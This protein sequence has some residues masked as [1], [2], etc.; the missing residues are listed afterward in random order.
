M[1]RR[2]ALCPLK[3]TLPL[4]GRNSVPPEFLTVR[5]GSEWGPGGIPL[6]RKHHCPNDIISACLAFLALHLTP[7]SLPPG[8]EHGDPIVF[9]RP[10]VIRSG[11][12]SAK[13]GV[14]LVFSSAKTKGL[15]HNGRYR[16]LVLGRNSEGDTVVIAAHR[17]ICWAIRGMP[18]SVEAYVCHATIGCEN[19]LAC[20]SPLHLEYGT[21]KQ[22]RG[23][24]ERRKTRIRVMRTRN[25]YDNW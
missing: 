8:I 14:C 5:H 17:L 15:R 23:D 11:I 7:G 16:Q 21:A 22:N 3:R 4:V 13:N 25:L 19:R 20:C 18:D 6:W 12:E 1:G 9:Q 24:V 10:P 2:K